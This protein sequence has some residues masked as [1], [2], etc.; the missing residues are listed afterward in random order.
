MNNFHVKKK[1]L[2]VG[3]VFNKENGSSSSQSGLCQSWSVPGRRHV[4]QPIKQIIESGLA[5]LA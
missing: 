5:L 3:L 2:G 1:L 4:F